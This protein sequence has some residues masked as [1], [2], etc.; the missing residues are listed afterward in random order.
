MALGGVVIAAL[1]A[2][3]TMY[4]EEKKPSAK[5]LSRDFI[6]GAVMVAMIMQLLPESTTSVIQYILALAPLS[7]FKSAPAAIAE[8]AEAA[9]GAVG[10]A[11]DDV[12]VKV[13]VPK[14]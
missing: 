6:I 14:F 11:T 10:A 5:S 4:V 2:G 7:L 8:S 9:F 3:S 1:G 13:G 12:E